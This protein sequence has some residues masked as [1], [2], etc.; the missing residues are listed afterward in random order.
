MFSHILTRGLSC[1]PILWGIHSYAAPALT[2]EAIE[3]G[4]LIDQDSLAVSEAIAKADRKGVISKEHRCLLKTMEQV[5]DI[6]ELLNDVP[7]NTVV[8]IVHR[9]S[10]ENRPRFMFSINLRNAPDADS[11]FPGSDLYS[12]D[13]RRSI[14][15]N[16]LSNVDTPDTSPLRQPV[17]SANVRIAQLAES[18]PCIPSKTAAHVKKGTVL[19]GVNETV[20]GGSIPVCEAEQ[21]DKIWL[22]FEVGHN[23]QFE[24]IGK[25]YISGFDFYPLIDNNPNPVD[26]VWRVR[27]YT[28]DIFFESNYFRLDTRASVYL[29][30]TLNTKE[31]V[32]FS[33]RENAV[34][35]LG[36]AQS[37]EGLLVDL[38]HLANHQTVAE[39]SDNWFAGNINSA[40]EVR[41]DSGTR[42]DIAN[43][44]VRPA[45][46][47]FR[48]VKNGLEFHGPEESNNKPEINLS[49]NFLQTESR[50]LLFYGKLNVSLSGNQIATAELMEPLYFNDE[51][52]Y[53]RPEVTISSS[54]ENIWFSNELDCPVIRDQFYLSGHLSLLVKP[55]DRRCDHDFGAE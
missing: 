36:A 51:N 2:S 7:E 45:R 23:D 11:T 15:Y 27:C 50:G 25:L 35:G 5:E 47:E 10:E 52:G 22:M 44:H 40:I 37:Q 49:Q 1:L 17:V 48:K 55:G 31:N 38:R 8:L 9:E 21:P 16:P 29:Q 3:C 43:N 46:S 30:C 32:Y 20:A 28:G 41:L 33:F 39:L 13:H 18:T 6:G 34:I 19:I 42:V 54:G 14:R 26:S 53:S 4:S 12:R 24:D